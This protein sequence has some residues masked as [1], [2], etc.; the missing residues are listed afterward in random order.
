[1]IPKTDV[2]CRERYVN[3]LDPEIDSKQNLEA[4]TEQ[5]SE[6]LME[7]IKEVVIENQGIPF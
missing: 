5:E 1:M 2:Q 6:N 3:C 7:A 4:W